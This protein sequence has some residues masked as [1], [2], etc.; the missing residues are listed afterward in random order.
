MNV[1]ARTVLA[2][3]NSC[4]GTDD[5]LEL[6][7]TLTALIFE[8]GHG[9]I[10]LIRTVVAPGGTCLDAIESPAGHKVGAGGATASSDYSG[11]TLGFSTPVHPE[12]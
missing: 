3:D 12:N 2:G 11:G 1:V 8:Y 6:R 4:G 7:S 9:S 5:P 10:S